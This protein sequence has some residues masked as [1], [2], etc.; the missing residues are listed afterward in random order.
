M[1]N[2]AGGEQADG[3]IFNLALVDSDDSRNH[4]H[5]LAA[6]QG[7]AKGWMEWMVVSDVYCTDCKLDFSLGLRFREMAN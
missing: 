4:S 7:S 6:V 1:V 3:D 2:G 5:L